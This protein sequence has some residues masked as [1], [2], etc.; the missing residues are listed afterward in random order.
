MTVR[1]VD[2]ANSLIAAMHALD[3]RALEIER[4]TDRA[5]FDW[6]PGGGAWTVGQIF[7]HLCVVNDDYLV[8]LRRLL[9]SP[10]PATHRDGVNAVWPPSF[11]GRLLTRSMASP[12]KLV[13][14]SKWR[15]APEARDNVIGEFLDRQHELERLIERSMDREWRHVRLSSPVSRF[16]RMNVGD[17]FTVIVRHAERH[18]RQIDSRLAELDAAH[19]HGVAP[20]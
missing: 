17:A 2:Q 19:A 15:P 11:A 3:A 4:T 14:P 6:Q 10:A 16:I 1:Q 7:D 5:S 18:F 9:A 13:T 8:V 12:R 20:L